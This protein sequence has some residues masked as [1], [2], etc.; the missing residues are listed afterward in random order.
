MQRII[1]HQR[2]YNRRAKRIETLI[3]VFGDKMITDYQ[4]VHRDY[5]NEFYEMRSINERQI[6]QI[7]KRQPR[8]L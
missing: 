4:V 8:V 1:L 7:S 5:F 6:H 3:E 2:Y